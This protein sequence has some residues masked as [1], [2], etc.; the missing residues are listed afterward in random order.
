MS[1]YLAPPHLFAREYVAAGLEQGMSRQP[2]V[3]AKGFFLATEAGIFVAGVG[4]FDTIDGPY[5]VVEDLVTNPRVPVRLRHEA[6]A[7][8]AEL[9]AGYAAI[10][11]RLMVMVVPSRG[12]AAILVRKYGWRP[13]GGVTLLFEPRPIP[14]LTKKTGAPTEAEAPARRTDDATR[15]IPRDPS[16]A[17]P[18]SRRKTK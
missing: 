2:V 3:P 12:R 5:T 10:H 6:A 9:L 4:L 11:C 7:V 8:I 15:T 1:L 18:R 16:V 17:R 13:Q 14:V